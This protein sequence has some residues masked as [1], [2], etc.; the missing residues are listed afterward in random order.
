MQ[1]SV[2][3]SLVESG[4]T[5]SG[6]DAPIFL[7]RKGVMVRHYHVVAVW[8]DGRREKIG[9][10]LRRP[11]AARWIRQKSAEWLAKYFSR[12]GEA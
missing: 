11:D 10:F 12:S 6:S 1:D 2:V 8:P 3:E 4:E 7:A 9:R 5:P